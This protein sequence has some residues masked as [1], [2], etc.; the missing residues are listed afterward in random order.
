MASLNGASHPV[1]SRVPWA[2]GLV[3]A[4]SG[5][6][7]PAQIDPIERNL[8][9]LGYDQALIGHGPDAAY[10]Y[11]YFNRPD[12]LG[13]D[14]ALRMVLAPAYLDSELGFKGLISKYTDFGVGLTGGAFGD[15][16]YDVEQG[17]YIET[18]SFYGSGGGS[19][20]SLYQLV[21]PGFKIP[22][23]AVARVGFHYASYF[24]ANTTGSHFKVPPDQLNAYDRFGLRLGGKQPILYPALGM[25]LSAWYQRERHFDDDPYGYHGDR[26][27]TPDTD[28]Y[29]AVASLDYTSKDTGDRLSFA[30]TA[31]GSTNAD[32]FT[33]W[34][35]GGVLP[36]GSELPLIIPGYYY[37]ELTAT[38]FVHFYGSYSVPL[39]HRR[40]WNL[41]FEAATARLVY[42]PG[43]AQ[44]SNWQSG[45]GTRITFA[46][47]KSYKI[48]L[49]YGYG[50][51]AIRYGRLGSDSV[52]LL[53]QYDFNAHKQPKDAVNN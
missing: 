15:N 46:A 35:L 27:I 6:R 12:F 11:Y 19:A 26:V 40:R 36:L 25:E 49:R 16:F 28:L 8:V 3:L 23:T 17:R 52:G 22:L 45:V 39:D 4:F 48:V 53:F 24:D 5:L 32:L 7:C 2:L 37:E 9:E 14:I 50:I 21:D 13:D 51:N 31:G 33:A 30:T 1:L 10:A 47:N 18:R 29:W 43:Y 34:R 41:G 20:L 44:T 38:R 42:F